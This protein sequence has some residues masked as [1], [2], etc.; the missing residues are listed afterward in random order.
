MTR[1]R[2]C[3]LVT[4]KS[5][6]G[7]C[8]RIHSQRP[9]C[10]C[11]PALLGPLSQVLD[12]WLFSPSHIWPHY[13]LQPKLTWLHRPPTPTHPPHVCLFNALFLSFFFFAE[14]PFNVLDADSSSLFFFSFSFF[15]IYIYFLIFRFFS[16]G[17]ISAYT[18]LSLPYIIYL[19]RTVLP[20]FELF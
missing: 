7:P 12:S 15:F 13:P 16:V 19:V 14:S 5:V 1:T 3:L 10:V 20:L 2:L 17:L 6:E 4:N 18:S 9:S 11:R 8:Q